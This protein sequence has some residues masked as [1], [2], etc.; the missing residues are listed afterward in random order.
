[1]GRG[2]VIT[3]RIV[4]DAKPVPGVTVGLWRDVHGYDSLLGSPEVTTDADGR[5]RFPHAPV[6]SGCWLYVPPG[7]LEQ[8]GVVPPRPLRT[9]AED[10]T[11]DLGD[12]AVQHGRTVSGRVIFADGKPLPAAEVVASADHAV[13]A[14]RT[15]PDRSGR[16]TLVGLPE[17]QVKVCVYFPEAKSYAPAGYRVSARNKCLDP[18]NPWRLVGRI[19]QDMADLTILFEP[20][21]QPAPNFAPDL[22]AVFKESQ[23]GPITG[24]PPGRDQ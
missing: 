2:T 1:M 6:D 19:D 15:K 12:I 14:L 3:G 5:F 7:N 22:Q 10:S 18:L 16:F 23:A 17:G 21:E 9:R 4:R 13:G 8:A 11:I 20:G 24:V